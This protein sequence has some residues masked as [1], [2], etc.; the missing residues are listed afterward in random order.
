MPDAFVSF[1]F[2]LSLCTASSLLALFC[3]PRSR[4]KG[5]GRGEAE[6]A[7]VPLPGR[8]WPRR[9]GAGTRRC[10]L[11]PRRSTTR[12][13]TSKLLRQ[14]APWLLSHSFAAAAAADAAADAAAERS[15]RQRETGSSEHASERFP[16]PLLERESAID[17]KGKV[18]AKEE[19]KTFVSNHT[20]LLRFFAVSRYA[21]FKGRRRGRRRPSSFGR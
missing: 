15:E 9:P 12:P 10:G 1:S 16:L 5:E 4:G 14:T 6:H 13:Q 19:K 20:F 21:P 8:P 17:E 7:E 3:R 11:S 2:S 18:K